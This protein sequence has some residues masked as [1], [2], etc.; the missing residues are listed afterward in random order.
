MGNIAKLPSWA[1]QHIAGLNTNIASLERRLERAMS[2]VR[3]RDDMLSSAIRALESIARLDKM[4][5]PTAYLIA[6]EALSV[7]EPE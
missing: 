4:L 2:Y 5:M 6:L 1:Q 3:G 7:I